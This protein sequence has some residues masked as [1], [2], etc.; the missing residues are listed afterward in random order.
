MQCYTAPPDFGRCVT[1]ELV[2]VG[3]DM[4]A[5]LFSAASGGVSGFGVHFAL[6]RPGMG[7]DLEELFP[8]DISIS[9]QSQHAFWNEHT[10]SDV[11]IF[12]TAEDI[13]GPGEGHF[14]EHR[15]MISAYVLRTADDFDAYYLEDRFMT[16]RKYD[17]VDSNDDVLA[18]ERQEIL[19]RLWRVKSE[20]EW[21]P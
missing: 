3:E 20:S 7:K 12:V 21:H 6:L 13:W 8:S 11:S 10:I 2:Q 1:V 18:S 15:Y 5:L 9:N 14:S 17:L 19:S 4:P 16:V